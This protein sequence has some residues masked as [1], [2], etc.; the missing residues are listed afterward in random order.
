MEP[1][2]LIFDMDGTLVDSQNV[3]FDTMNDAFLSEGLAPPTRDVALGLV[4]LSLPETMEILAPNTSAVT[5]Q[6]LVDAYKGGFLA[7]RKTGKE[8]PLYAGARECLFSLNAVPE[9]VLGVAT[10]KA[11]RGVNH[12]VEAHELHGLFTTVM[13]A[14][15]NPSKPHPA[16]VTACCDDTGIPPSRAIMIGDTSFDMQ[17]GRAAGVATIGVT[18]GYHSA[19]R[20]AASDPAHTVADFAALTE[21]IETVTGMKTCLPA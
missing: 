17:M 7:R 4:G 18:W 5:R 1:W 3:I 20:L 12:T 10:G 2:L 9:F 8:S 6:R 13:T 14:D 15:T 16:M 11:M 21:T 19:D